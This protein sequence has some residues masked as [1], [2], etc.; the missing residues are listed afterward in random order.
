MAT[1]II[2]KEEAINRIGGMISELDHFDVNQMYRD[3]E[4]LKSQ[5]EDNDPDWR[6]TWDETILGCDPWGISGM[7]WALN[8]KNDLGYAEV[9]GDEETA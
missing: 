9:E 8:T 5:L 4:R 6:E 3:L 1:E 2:T 7:E